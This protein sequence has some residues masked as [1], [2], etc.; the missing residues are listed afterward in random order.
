MINVEPKTLTATSHGDMAK[1]NKVF[2][3]AELDYFLYVRLE[4][5]LSTAWYLYRIEEK[6]KDGTLK[7]MPFDKTVK[8]ESPTWLKFKTDFINKEIGLHIYKVTF[9]NTVTDVLASLWFSY[10]IQNDNP[11]KPYVYMTRDKVENDIV[12]EARELGLPNLPE[13]DRE[14]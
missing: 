9:V 5:P 4:P 7:E 6:Q 3:L 8:R 10:T 13:I 12:A 11:D 2:N 1:N 14:V